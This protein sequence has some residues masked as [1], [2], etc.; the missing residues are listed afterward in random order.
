MDLQEDA[1]SRRRRVMPRRLSR[2]YAQHDGRRGLVGRFYEPYGRLDE[3]ESL[4]FNPLLD[5]ARIFN[6]RHCLNVSRP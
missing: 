3:V 6:T 2:K 4:E 1:T 5:G